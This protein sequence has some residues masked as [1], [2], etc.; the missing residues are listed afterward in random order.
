[1]PSR[2]NALVIRKK[3]TLSRKRLVEINNTFADYNL[4]GNYV[5]EYIYNDYWQNT[6]KTLCCKYTLCRFIAKEKAMACDFIENVLILSYMPV[7]LQKIICSF[8]DSGPL[9]LEEAN[10]PFELR[11]RTSKYLKKIQLN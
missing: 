10:Y 6:N 3:C 4:S 8:L 11:Q 7:V 2:N 1:M 9:L 5:K